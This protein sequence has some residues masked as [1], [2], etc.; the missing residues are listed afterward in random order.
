[1]KAQ[2]P[3]QG[4]GSWIQTE[5]KATLDALLADHVEKNHGSVEQRH[6]K[7]L[8]KLRE[9]IGNVLAG[10]RM[11]KS[12]ARELYNEVSDLLKAPRAQEEIIDAGNSS[13]SVHETLHVDSQSSAIENGGDVPATERGIREET[14]A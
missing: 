8:K 12:K 6:A 10:T 2:C 3:E 11:A 7:T 1:M 13:V 9:E 5:D 4:C 14:G